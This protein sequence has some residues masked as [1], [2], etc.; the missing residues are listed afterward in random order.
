[1]PTTPMKPKKRAVPIPTAL[2]KD[3]DALVGRG[4]RS[5]WA[6]RIVAREIRKLK[7]L[8]AVDDGQKPE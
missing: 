8:R 4:N 2:A 1:M 7:L 5:A 6:T 3:I